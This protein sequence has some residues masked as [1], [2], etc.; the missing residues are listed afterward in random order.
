MFSNDTHGGKVSIIGFLSEESKCFSNKKTKSL[1]ISSDILI[2]DRRVRAIPL[3]MDE[4]VHEA[5]FGV[6][7]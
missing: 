6:E 5:G 7:S 2:L 3:E 4:G 1:E